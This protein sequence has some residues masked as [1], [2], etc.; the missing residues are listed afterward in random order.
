MSIIGL[1]V[2]ILYI[3]LVCVVAFGVLRLLAALGV[4]LHPVVPVTVQFV[5]GIICIIILIDWLTGNT[6]GWPLFPIHR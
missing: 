3:A 2:A 4:P 1:L 6:A 5:V